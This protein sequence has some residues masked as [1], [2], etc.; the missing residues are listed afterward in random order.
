M[1]TVDSIL[2]SGEGFDIIQ[3]ALDNVEARLYMDRQCG[4]QKPL[5]DA[6]T[7]GPKETFKW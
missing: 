5:V 6:G 3:N 2:S 1:K 7:L 4:S